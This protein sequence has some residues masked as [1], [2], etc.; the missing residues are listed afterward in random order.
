MDA[1]QARRL[2]T[3][4]ATPLEVAGVWVF[5]RVLA[6]VHIR[7]ASLRASKVTPLKVA[8]VSEFV[9]FGFCRDR[10]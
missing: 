8:G 6:L 5:A 4:M 1:R 7:M 3:S 2:R 10:I 9:L